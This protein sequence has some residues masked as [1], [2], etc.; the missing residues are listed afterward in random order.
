MI[1]HKRIK[2]G[3]KHI[4]AL[5]FNLSGKN[6]IV[7][8]GGKGFI[9]CGYLN[10]RAAERFKDAAVKITGVAT[11]ED[12]LCSSVHSCTSVARKMGVHKGQSVKDALRIIA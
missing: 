10:L 2:I 12:A 8:R 7:L 11:I 4:D 1:R 9:M 3:K 5:S 6:L